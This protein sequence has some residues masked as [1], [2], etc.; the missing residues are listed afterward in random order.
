MDQTRK[1]LVYFV[2]YLHK[3]LVKIFIK[4][5]TATIEVSARKPTE[6]NTISLKVFEFVYFKGR[7]FRG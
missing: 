5:P 4:G 6:F 7:K 1:D 3:Y 2:K